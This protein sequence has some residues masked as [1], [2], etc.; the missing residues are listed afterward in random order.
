MKTEVKLRYY[1]TPP[2]EWLADPFNVYE[3]KRLFVDEVE[4]GEE[5]Y[6]LTA[7]HLEQSWCIDVDNVEHIR[8]PGHPDHPETRNH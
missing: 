4:K 6:R 3:S 5:S 7:S 1:L 8:P 2:D